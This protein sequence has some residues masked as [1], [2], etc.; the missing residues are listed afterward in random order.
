[1]SWLKLTYMEA[2]WVMNWLF[3]GKISWFMTRNIQIQNNPFESYADSNYCFCKLLEHEL[4]QNQLLRK[5][6]E[7]WV[8]LNRCFRKTLES[9]V[10]SESMFSESSWVMIWTRINSCEGHLS[11]ELNWIKT[12]ARWIDSNRIKVSRI[13]VLKRTHGDH[14]AVGLHSHL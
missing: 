4:N 11:H 6:I 3:T 10:E 7:S 5:S 2:I 1:M 14:G 12:F 9:Y 13:H 8:D